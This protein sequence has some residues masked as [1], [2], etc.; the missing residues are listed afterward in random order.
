MKRK[1]LLTL[2]AILPLSGCVYGSTSLAFTLDASTLDIYNDFE[3]RDLKVQGFVF[4]YTNVYRN[5][6]NEFVF[7][8]TGVFL[9]KNGFPDNMLTLNNI[10]GFSI[11]GLDQYGEIIEEIHPSF[12]RSESLETNEYNFLLTGYINFLIENNFDEDNTLGIMKFWS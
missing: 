9:S 3:A 5:D 1:L 12:K 10:V 7:K 8:D 4:S 11:Y 6:K 2:L